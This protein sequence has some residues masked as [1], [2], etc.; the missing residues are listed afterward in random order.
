MLRFGL[1]AYVFVVAAVTVEVE[2]EGG[3]KSTMVS[4]SSPCYDLTG[5]DEFRHTWSSLRTT[6]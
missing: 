5:T 4:V 1:T 2:L 3:L 6:Q